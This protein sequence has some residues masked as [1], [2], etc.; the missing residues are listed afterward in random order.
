LS[1]ADPQDGH[2]TE[3]RSPIVAVIP[4][5]NE[6]RFIGSVVLRARKHVDTVIVVDDGSADE[7]AQ[8]AEAAGAVV[9]RHEKNLGK[10]A[11]LSS[12][13]EE[14]RK[15][16]PR[17]VVVLDGDGQHH[18]NEI[19]L[20]LQP[21]LQGDAE[22]AVG[23]RF[24]EAEPGVPHVRRLGLRAITLLSNLG[25]GVSLSDSQMGF[26]AFSGEAVQRMFWRAQGFSVESEMQFLAQHLGLR[27]SE[28]PVSIDYEGAPKRNVLGQGLQVL[29]GILR[30]VGQYR[31]LLF[32]GLPGLVML[33]IGLW[34]GY[35]V[36]DIYRRAQE[37]AVGYALLAVLFA[38]LGSVTLSAGIT[39]HSLRGLLLE[40]LG[41]RE[42]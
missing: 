37:L 31:P 17:A 18:A 35:R 8:I 11:A 19:P 10:G 22:M 28:V 23:S 42:T 14:A 20:L 6:E 15:M 4:A 41:P 2:D 1:E 29:N 32:L 5:L 24:L 27:I 39:L 12:G 9:I 30:L 33:L 16:S 34:W 38:I 36:M 7:T 40:L 21:V 3:Q 26:R 25:S 13:F